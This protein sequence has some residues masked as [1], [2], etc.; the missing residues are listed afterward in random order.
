MKVLKVLFTVAGI[1][2]LVLIAAFVAAGLA[3]PAERSFRNEIDIGAP[4]ERVWRVIAD[5]GSYTA[6]Q[7]GLTRVDVIDDTHW[8]EYP[9]DS[10]EPL[11]F[12]VDRDQRPSSMSFS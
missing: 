12:S 7:T 11:M 5:R 9:K 10:P 4:S 8:V 2:V 1:L 6:W 3:I